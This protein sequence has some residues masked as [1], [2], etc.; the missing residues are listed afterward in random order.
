MIKITNYT[1]EFSDTIINKTINQ[2][3]VDYGETKEI[4]SPDESFIIQ[5]RLDEHGELY[6]RNCSIPV[7]RFPTEI[8]N[9]ILHSNPNAPV[10]KF[11]GVRYLF[12]DDKS[13]LQGFEVDKERYT[14][15]GI[16]DSVYSLCTVEEMSKHCFGYLRSNSPSTS[17]YN[18]G[19][20]AYKE[21]LEFV[22]SKHSLSDKEY[23]QV[24]ESFEKF[25]RIYPDV[26]SLCYGYKDGI[27][28]FYYF[29]RLDTDS[30][31]MKGE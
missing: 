25:L 23:V 22:K 6:F 11:K 5:Y 15:E 26:S 4:L 8:N 14:P 21:I 29:G 12:E 17:Y 16:Y 18:F 27:H 20:S 3:L 10:D 13:T 1:R 30:C 2:F 7:N 28:C 9:N 19:F 31:I 24:L